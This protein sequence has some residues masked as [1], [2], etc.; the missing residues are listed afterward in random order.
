MPRHAAP[1]HVIALSGPLTEGTG[2]TL[3]AEIGALTLAIREE[4]Q[5][6]WFTLAE[7]AAETN[8]PL[9]TLK[10]LV[11]TTGVP[12]VGQGRGQRLSGAALTLLRQRAEARAAGIPA[13]QPEDSDEPTELL[14]QGGGPAPGGRSGG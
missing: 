3:A 10:H 6:R 9:Q 12:T 4:Y 5:N 8:L 14:S 1:C 7:A 11:R 13:F 2:R